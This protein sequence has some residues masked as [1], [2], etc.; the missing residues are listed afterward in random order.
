[1]AR[2]TNRITKGTGIFSCSCCGRKTRDVGN[3]DNELV[4]MCEECYN[5]AGM[6]NEHSDSGSTNTEAASAL[7]FAIKARGDASAFDSLMKSL[8]VDITKTPVKVKAEVVADMRKVSGVW[9]KPT[10]VTNDEEAMDVM[11][12]GIR[13]RGVLARKPDKTL[14]V[15]S[16]K[17][18]K[19]HG[20]VIEADTN[21]RP[22]EPAPPKASAK[23]AERLAKLNATKEE[24]IED[25]L[26]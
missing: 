3:G 6:E 1:M 10:T 13:R 23:R 12:D 24:S 19:K 4:G 21:A 5:L 20:W 15:C 26:G 18:A 16:R 22:K 14:V 7:Y 11:A 9:L 17:T 2:T 25:L 8:G